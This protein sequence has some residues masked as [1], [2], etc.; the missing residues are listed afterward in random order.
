MPRSALGA[1]LR[2]PRH[3]RRHHPMP[4]S[5]GGAAGAARAAAARRGRPRRGVGL[6]RPPARLRHRL[7]RRPRL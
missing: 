1:T 7:E 2:A 5:A 4:R 3:A 6:L